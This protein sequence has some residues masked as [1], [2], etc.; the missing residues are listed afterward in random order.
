MIFSNLFHKSNKQESKV[1][2]LPLHDMST[3][4]ISELEEDKREEVQNKD[5]ANS[6]PL[7]VTYVTSW[8]IDIIYGYL[9]KDYS[10]QGFSDAMVNS[11]I[12]FKDINLRIIKN[13]ILMTFR[14]VNLKYDALDRYLDTKIQKC[15]QA[16][17]I[18]TVAELEQQKSII[19]THKSSMLLSK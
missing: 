19:E 17:L 2:T 5:G 7:T 1:V 11:D 13:R 9:R 12:S 18:S 3:A 10:S 4:P 6:Q 15:A 16:G 8:P 14:E